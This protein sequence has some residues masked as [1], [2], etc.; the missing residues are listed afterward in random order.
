LSLAPDEL[1]LCLDPADLNEYIVRTPK[2]FPTLEELAAKLVGKKFF[3]VLDLSEGFHHCS[4]DEESSWKCF[5]ATPMDS[6]MLQKSSKRKWR[7]ISVVFQ[8]CAFYFYDCL[9]TG[10]T[11]EAHDR[12]LTLVVQKAKQIGARFNKEKIQYKQPQVRFLGQLFSETG[13]EIDPDRTEALFSLKSPTCKEELQRLIGSFNYLR[14]Y[15]PGIANLMQNLC[16]LLRKDVE[17][18]W[19]PAHEASFKSLK[20]SITESPA[21]TPFDPSKRV[22]LQNDASKF[23]IGSCLFQVHGSEWKLVACASRSMSSS[24]LNYSQCE[25]E[26]LALYFGVKKFHR[27]VYGLKGE[28]H[29]DHKLIVFIMR[30]PISSI[31]SARL[32]L[33]RL[34]LLRYDLDV[35]FVPGKDLH[36]PDMLSR[37]PLK[38]ANED[39]ELTRD[40]SLDYQDSAYQ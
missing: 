25:K 28:A 4:L 17:W 33:L 34:K 1:R 39:P 14:R 27:Y 21:L 2:L 6:K 23:G 19:L 5:F 11:E 40:G 24:E 20:E 13:M 32:Q 36:F 31:G 37:D 26:M 22:I 29:T 8:M 3:T 10:E 7:S 12:A 38:E 16:N 18:K 35:K 15:V 30:K 9:V